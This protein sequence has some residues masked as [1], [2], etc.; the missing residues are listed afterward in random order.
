MEL[1]CL[2]TLAVCRCR[3]GFVA[4]SQASVISVSLSRHLLFG[5]NSY[6]KPIKQRF[7]LYLRSF[8][9]SSASLALPNYTGVLSGC[10]LLQRNLN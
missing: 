8:G 6:G 5:A 4:V 9:H 3:F 1:F 10:D 2:H 7:E